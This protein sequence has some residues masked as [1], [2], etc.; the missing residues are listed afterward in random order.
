MT[1][2]QQFIRR[3]GRPLYETFVYWL[4]ED[5]VDDYHFDNIHFFLKKGR[6]ASKTSGSS[7]LASKPYQGSLSAGVEHVPNEGSID[8]AY[9]CTSR[10]VRLLL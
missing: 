4:R 3:F 8:G 9:G 2:K 7:I 10:S 5:A 1:E 6:E